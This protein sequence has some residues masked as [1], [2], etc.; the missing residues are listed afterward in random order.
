MHDGQLWWERLGLECGVY[1]SSVPI[2]TRSTAAHSDN[3]SR[4]GKDDDTSTS[5]STNS[6]SARCLSDV[7]NNDDASSSSSSS[8]GTSISTSTSSSAP[9]PSSS[10]TFTSPPAD[11]LNPDDDSIIHDIE[12]MILFYELIADTRNERWNHVRMDWEEHED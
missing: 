3:K 11:S 12:D 2:I 6:S 10:D 4:L 5:S 8:S 9:S 1:Y 7:N